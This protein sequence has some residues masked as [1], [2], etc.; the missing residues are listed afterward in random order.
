MIIGTFRIGEDIALALDAVAGDI[1]NIQQITANLS[2]SKQRT[3]F[4]LDTE[5]T[6]VTMLV[7]D[8]SA[9]GA[10]PAGWTISLAAS[11]TTSLKPGLYGIDARMVDANGN[12]DITEE[13]ALIRVTKGAI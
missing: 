11:Q 5:F 9:E 10:N 4:E 3:H 12:V 6:A 7:S 1:A 8:R 2:A 13:T